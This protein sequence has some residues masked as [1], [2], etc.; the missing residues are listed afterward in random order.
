MGR[1]GDMVGAS[2]AMQRVYDLI[3]RVAPTASTV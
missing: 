2:D 1:F 3:I